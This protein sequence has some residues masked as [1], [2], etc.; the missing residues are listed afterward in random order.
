MLTALVLIGVD[1]VMK[2][3]KREIKFPHH[4]FQEVR[5]GNNHL[6]L[7]TY[8]QDLYNAMFAAI[9]GAQKYIYLESFIWKN[10]EIGYKFRDLL[11]QKAH[12]GVDVYVIFDSFGNMVV[13]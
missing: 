6:Q 2:R 10:D 5:V 3:K 1:A 13:P 9:E 8:G 11:A 12:E 7:F 4:D